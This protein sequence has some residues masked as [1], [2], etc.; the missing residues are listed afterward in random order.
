MVE[1]AYLK[2]LPRP[3]STISFNLSL[4]PKR[5][6]MSANL[7]SSRKWNRDT[8]T[9]QNSPRYSNFSDYLP[10]DALIY[11]LPTRTPLCRGRVKVLCKQTTPGKPIK[12]TRGHCAQLIFLEHVRLDVYCAPSSRCFTT[13]MNL[14]ID[15][16]EN[17][18]NRGPKRTKGRSVVIPLLS[19]IICPKKKLHSSTLTT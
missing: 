16:H 10:R 1:V 19:N 15:M 5:S 2:A 11:T 12:L 14:N 7:R 17:E 18:G 13:R 6:R 4:P 9:L 3:P 8:E